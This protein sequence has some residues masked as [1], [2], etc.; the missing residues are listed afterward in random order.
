MDK[1][2]KLQRRRKTI[3]KKIRG[4]GERPRM[5]IYK[6]LSNMTAQIIDDVEGK[7]LCG[8]STM[9][10]AI[11]GKITGKTK[12]NQKAVEILGAEVAK[13]AVA[14]GIKKVVFDRSGYSYHGNV[15]AFA[16]SARKNGLEF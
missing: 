14:K 16:E 11:S 7:T 3:R 8:L 5:C 2:I 1:N 4:S 6:S 12:K 15:K 9:S 13:L 10:K